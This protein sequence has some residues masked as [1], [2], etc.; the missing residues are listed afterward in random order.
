MGLIFKFDSKVRGQYVIYLRWD[1]FIVK[2]PEEGGLEKGGSEKAGWLKDG[3]K[4]VVQSR[5][6]W[7]K[8]GQSRDDWNKVVR[9]RDGW[10]KAGQSRD[11]WKKVVRSRDG[12][13]KACL[14]PTKYPS[15]TKYL[16]GT[17]H[18]LFQLITNYL[19]AT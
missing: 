14:V 11:G 5:D 16:D 8:A 18:S 10:N 4:K 2:A 15:P 6:G 12:W 17:R 7:N 1:F 9:S 3:W 13:N 19:V